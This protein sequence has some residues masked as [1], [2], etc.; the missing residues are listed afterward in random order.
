MRFALFLVPF[1]IA[2]SCGGVISGGTDA[3]S[4]ASSTCSTDSDCPKGD[5][6][7]FPVNGGC[8]ATRACLLANVECKGLPAC[9][10]DGTDVSACGPGAI[11][12]IAHSGPCEGPPPSCASGLACEVCDVTAFAPTPQSPPFASINACSSS[13][14]ADLVTA[15]LSSSATSATCSTWQSANAGPCAACV[16]TPSTSMNWGPIV[17]RSD[18]SSALDSGGC[19]DLTLQEVAQ[20]KA[21]GG[22]GSCGDAYN[23]ELE[24]IAY[25]C[26]KCI[27]T[28]D[29]TTCSTSAAVNECQPYVQAVKTSPLCG[30]L[31]AT[32]CFPQS[33]VDFAALINVF[34]GTGP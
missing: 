25:S 30:G 12:P 29:S 1:A 31:D 33:D 18:G 16:V 13:Q 4:D 10:C 21:T 15:C 7:L 5:A 24:C 11:K 22:S 27:G 26:G 9:A 23:D 6:C 28:A 20:E 17:R 2:A 8:S 34:C 19:V 3:G 32:V 14:I